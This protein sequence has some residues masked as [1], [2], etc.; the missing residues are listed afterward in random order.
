MRYLPF[1]GHEMLSKETAMAAKSGLIVISVK[2]DLITKV[3][4]PLQER[5]IISHLSWS[6]CKGLVLDRLR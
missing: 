6:L 3:Q 4:L 2:N 1:V 5:R